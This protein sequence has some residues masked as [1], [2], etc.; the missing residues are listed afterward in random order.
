MTLPQIIN[1]I[2][3]GNSN[4]GGRTIAIGEQRSTCAVSALSADKLRRILAAAVEVD[5]PI[6]FSLIIT[7]AA[8]C[9]CSRDNATDT[10]THLA[11]SAKTWNLD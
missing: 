1:A 11:I 8:S 5:K 9:P 4:V 3:S 6:F 2:S 10:V 7:I